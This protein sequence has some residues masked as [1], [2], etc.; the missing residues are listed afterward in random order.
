MSKNQSSLLKSIEQIIQSLKSK[1]SLTR[2]FAMILTGKSMVIFSSLLLTPVLSRIYTPAN[3]GLFAVYSLIVNNFAVISTF[4]LAEALPIVEK[5][6]L[7][8]LV[9]LSS[10]VLLVLSIILFI[11]IEPL[12]EAFSPNEYAKYAHVISCGAF[13]AGYLGIITKLNIVEN[14]FGFAAS[15][16][17]SS[18]F[19][20]KT[21]STLIGIFA[22]LKAGLLL[23]EL[24]SRIFALLA[25]SLFHHKIIING[26]RNFSVTRSLAVLKEFKGYL[27]AI[28][29]QRYLDVL[30][31]QLIIVL[32]GYSHGIQNLGYFAMSIGLLQLPVNLLGNSLGP[33][34]LR[35]ILKSS[36]HE[37]LQSTNKVVSLLLTLIII[38]AL[39]ITFFGVEI[40]TFVLGDQWLI[41]GRF[42]S[43]MAPSFLFF[44]VPQVLNAIPKVLRKEKVLLLNSIILVIG[45]IVFLI[46]GFLKQH[47]VLIIWSYSMGTLL[48]HISN[49]HR[50]LRLINFKPEN[51]HI[52]I[53][54]LLVILVGFKGVQVFFDNS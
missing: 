7:N 5:K 14:T 9:N 52:S 17:A 12:I 19:I 46:P 44:I 34:F 21:S 26:F 40:L 24:I 42:A 18:S 54:A 10:L 1:G 47:L 13:L 22:Q 15:V 6:R 39:I 41:S 51:R 16:D 35:K 20:G 25:N 38:P 37:I 31:G 28:F 30:S 33:A 49:A 4:S 27:S 43:I 45:I 36:T 48:I 50:I 32:I 3:Y 2:N 11:I 8:D 53:V 29:P 23:G